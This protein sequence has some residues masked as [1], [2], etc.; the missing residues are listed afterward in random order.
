LHSEGW[1]QKFSGGW[2]F[3]PTDLIQVSWQVLRKRWKLAAAGRPED[4]AAAASLVTE[5][6]SNFRAGA[7]PTGKIAII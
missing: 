5:V 1:Y 3:D 7:P 2:K 6:R 4:L